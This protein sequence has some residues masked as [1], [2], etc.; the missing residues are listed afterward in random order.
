MWCVSLCGCGGIN[1]QLYCFTVS[2][3]PHITL[4]LGMQHL[5][6]FYYISDIFEGREERRTEEKDN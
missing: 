5:K 2:L 4:L 6:K 3:S 1:S